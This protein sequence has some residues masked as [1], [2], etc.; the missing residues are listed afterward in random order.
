MD[1]KKF[2]RERLEEACAIGAGIMDQIHIISEI[3]TALEAVRWNGGRLFICGV[4]GGAGNGTHF[5]GDVFK[6]CEIQTICLTDNVPTLTAFTNDEGWNEVFVQQ[7]KV[8]NL[9]KFDAL[10]VFS[11]GGGDA[12]RHISANIV[13]AIDHAKD[14]LAKVLGIVGK[15]NGY[16]AQNGDS[17]VVIP[18]FNPDFMTTHTEGW[19]GYLSHFIVECLRKRGA[20]W[21]TTK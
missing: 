5:A 17:V 21:E 9:T 8:W 11:V 20:K 19:Q 15:E 10:F 3:V 18:N 16:T 7:L 2:L 14:R 12:Q 1:Q 4:G 6:S 13:K